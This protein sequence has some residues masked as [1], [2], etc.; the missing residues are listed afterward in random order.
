MDIVRI[1]R[2]EWLEQGKKLFGDNLIKWKF[3][4]PSCGNIQ[5][6]EDFINIGVDPENAYFNCIGRFTGSANEIG[7]K[8]QP[9]NYSSG[10]LFVLSLLR[11]VS[12][13]KE[14]IVFDFAK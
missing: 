5:A 2:E 3:R 11:V 6:P 9:C 10:G 14:K 12:K 13:G 1:S 4:C 7:S 8:K